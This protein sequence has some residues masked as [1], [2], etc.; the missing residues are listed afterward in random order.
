M[1]IQEDRIV[2]IINPK[3]ERGEEELLR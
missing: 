3:L 2:R 1:E